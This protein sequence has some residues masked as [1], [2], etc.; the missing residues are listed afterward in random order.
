MANKK[1]A[2]IPLVYRVLAVV[3]IVLFLGWMMMSVWS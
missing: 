3:L 1:P 2:P